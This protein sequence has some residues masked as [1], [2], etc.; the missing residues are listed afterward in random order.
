M[1]DSTT[2]SGP[3]T[4]VATQ[5]DSARAMSKDTANPIAGT[6][7]EQAGA[8]AE[9]SKQQAQEVARDAK[10]H[11]RDVVAQS[12]DQLRGQAQE[13]AQQLAGTLGEL[14]GQLHAMARGEG[15]PEGVV[16]DVTRQLGSAATQASERLK[17]GGFE[18]LV[19]DVKRFAR[20]KPALFLLAS[21][22]AGFA[23][24]RVVRAADSHALVEAAKP[25]TA[26]SST[27]PLEPSAKAIDLRNGGL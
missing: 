19:G 6:A 13:Q 8:V 24:T 21:A 5:D 20:E 9:A 16:G 1:T 27:L 14:G 12:R 15:A 2:S 22:G 3:G 25:S 18:E 10:A 26:E 23:L 4:S 17:A 11:V 7:K